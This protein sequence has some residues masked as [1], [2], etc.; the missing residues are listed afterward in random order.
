MAQKLGPETEILEKKGL[1]GNLLS[2]SQRQDMFT[3]QFYS[4][5]ASISKHLSKIKEKRTL[6]FLL[7]TVL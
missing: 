4:K 2:L 5:V 3:K 7:T 1:V 6:T